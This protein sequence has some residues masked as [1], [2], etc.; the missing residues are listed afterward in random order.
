MKHVLMIN[1]DTQVNVPKKLDT[2][3]Y[4]IESFKNLNCELN[5]NLKRF[6]KTRQFTYIHCTVF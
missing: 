1:D 6:K 4:A 2:R 3:S 5:Y